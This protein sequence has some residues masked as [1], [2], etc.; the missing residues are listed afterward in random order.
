MIKYK[1]IREELIK[2][3]MY[4]K[5]CTQ[6]YDIDKPMPPK[7]FFSFYMKYISKKAEP[8]LEPMCG[9]GR[10]LI[11]ILEKNFDIDGVD[12]SSDMIDAC[13]SK[14][15]IK[16]LSTNLYKQFLDELDL[17]RQYGLVFIP[18]GSLGLI[19][20]E[21][22]LL[23]SLKKIYKHM[24]SGGRFLTELET[25]YAKPKE[26]GKVTATFRE[27][28]DGSK[29]VLS[30]FC[31]SYNENKKVSTSINKYELFKNGE[32]IETEL[33]E[34]KVR[35]FDIDEFRNIL[36]GIGFKDIKVFRLYERVQPSTDEPGVIFECR[37]P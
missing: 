35:Y 20:E 21:A 22:L 24:V 18:E 8:I 6:F 2:M 36:K 1:N 13:K 37:K 11:P 10:F 26:I 31:D 27:R 15:S 17:P 4:K 7:S 30:R 3:E 34:F 16:G 28:S 25:P 12:A 9:S 19:I 23:N 33:E 29:I 14:M 32:L 5:L